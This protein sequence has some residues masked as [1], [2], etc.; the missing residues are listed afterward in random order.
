MDIYYYFERSLLC[1]PRL[2]LFD[3]KSKKKKKEKERKKKQQCYTS[4]HFKITFYIYHLFLWWQI[5]TVFSVTWHDPS[6][7]FLTCYQCCQAFL[8]KLMRQTFGVSMKII[9]METGKS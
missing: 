9:W 7:N 1:L 5:W 4:S 2:Y 3:G 8:W 6:E